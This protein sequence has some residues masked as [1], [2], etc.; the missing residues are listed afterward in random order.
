MKRSELL[1][2]AG[3]KDKSG[4]KFEFDAV[5]EDS[6]RA[7]PGALFVAMQGE[8]TDGHDHIADAAARGAV[9]VLGDRK[10]PPEDCPLPYVYCATPRRAAGLI[11]HELAGNPSNDLVVIGITGTNGKTSTARLTQVI[12]EH[13]GYPTANFGTIGYFIGNEMLPA[14]HTTPFPEELADCFARARDAAQAAVVMEV[15]SH[16]LAQ[17]RIA[18]IA[19][20]VAAFTNLTQDHLDF[21]H[22]MK[23]Y[24][25]AKEKLF[26]DLRGDDAFGVVNV[27][28]PA[29]SHFLKASSAECLTYGAKGDCR[30][31]KIKV[32]L[33]ATRFDLRTPWGKCA[34]ELPLLGLHNVANALCAVT[35]CGGLGIPLE[36]LVAGLQAVKNVPGRF[37][38]VNAGQ[39]FVV[40]V[41]YAHTEDGLRNVLAAARAICKKRVICVFGCGGDRDRTKRPKMGAAAAELADYSI[42]TSDNPR[43]EDPHRILL[44]VEVGVQRLHK[45]GVAYEVI[46]DRTEAIQTAIRM[47]KKGDLVLIAG[48]GHEDYQIIGTT[49]HHF[50]DREVAQTALENLRG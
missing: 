18:G 11:A 33:D 7:R 40:V 39:D 45:K 23:Q 42:I 32:A 41:D 10:T 12:L 29:A 25:K 38:R 48:K 28:D 19:F 49:K 37:E 44:D 16:A 13:A 17:D 24:R 43:T 14:A 30:A 9:A 15:S 22:D 8:H 50:D 26:R 1:N 27:D 6:R 20:K 46:A 2:L 21:H 5:T 4:V 47:A 3:A 36:T 34:V 31:K 35:I